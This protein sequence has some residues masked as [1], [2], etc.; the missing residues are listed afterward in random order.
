MQVRRRRPF[1]RRRNLRESSVA[2][3]V[4]PRSRRAGY[5]LPFFAGAFF[6]GF[7][8]AG[9]AFGAAFTAFLGATFAFG[10]A[11]AAFFAAA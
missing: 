9:F 6:T 5:F 7:F 10:A 4:L 1:G 8:G 11:L 2:G 3:R